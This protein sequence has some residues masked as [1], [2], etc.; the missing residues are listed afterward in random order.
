MAGLFDDSACTALTP[1]LLNSSAHFSL[2]DVKDPAKEDENEVRPNAQQDSVHF[3]GGVK[4][5]DQIVPRRT[6]VKTP[7]PIEP[8]S[9]NC[10]VRK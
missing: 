3:F 6:A 9:A 2:G 10:S 1:E 7:D 5:P 8:T 4:P